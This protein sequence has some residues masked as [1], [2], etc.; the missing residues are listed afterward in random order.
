MVPTAPPM[1]APERAPAPA[2][3]PVP[4][5]VVPPPSRAAGSAVAVE[6]MAVLEVSDESSGNGARQTAALGSIVGG[7]SVELP[8]TRASRRASPARP[9]PV[10]GEPS[11][12]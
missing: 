12:R 4:R 5:T 11:G 7:I 6:A 9:G 3:P 2:P 1:P 8:S 10:V